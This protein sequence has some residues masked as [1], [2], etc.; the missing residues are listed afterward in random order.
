MPVKLTVPCARLIR[1]KWF[2]SSVPEHIAGRHAL[3][4]HTLSKHVERGGTCLN[5]LPWFGS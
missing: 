2:S 3:T 4:S 5:T 1:G